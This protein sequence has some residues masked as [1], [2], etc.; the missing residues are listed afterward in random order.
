ME[1]PKYIC[2]KLV[3]KLLFRPKYVK[4]FERPLYHSMVFIC[5]VVVITP[6]TSDE[7][8]QVRE[9]QCIYA[10]LHLTNSKSYQMQ[11]HPIHFPK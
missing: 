5:I 2:L 4:I 3:L 10:F 8:A 6:V 7:F 9:I 1:L 11:I